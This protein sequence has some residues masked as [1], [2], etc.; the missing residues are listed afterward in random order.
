F[1]PAADYEALIMESR[2]R[3][4]F[5]ASPDS[6]LLLKKATGQVSHGGG[7]RLALDSLHYQRLRRWIV[8][9]GRFDPSTSEASI[10]LEVQPGEQILAF[11]GTQQ[12]RVV[13]VDGGKRRCVT[14]DAQFDSNAP[15]IAKVDARGWVQATGIPG[16][17][18]IL[19]RYLGHVTICRVTVPRTGTAF[20]R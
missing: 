7:R 8:E 16:Q 6:S 18:A 1:D 2:G 13:A 14:A 19:V 9:G 12:L 5:P 4:I 15:T 17:A 11:D 10:T 20:T 3:R